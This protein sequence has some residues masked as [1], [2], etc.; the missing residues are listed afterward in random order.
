MNRWDTNSNTCTL[1]ALGIAGF[2]VV[3]GKQA[4]ILGLPSFRE[5]MVHK[6]LLCYTDGFQHCAWRRSGGWDGAWICT[7][8]VLPVMMYN[9]HSPGPSLPGTSCSKTRRPVLQCT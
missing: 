9:V 7:T 3:Y 2:G 1:T 4:V 8:R 5:V 6:I